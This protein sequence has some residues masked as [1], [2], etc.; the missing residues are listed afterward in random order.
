MAMP[1]NKDG[2]SKL[3]ELQN[4][5]PISDKIFLDTKEA[6]ALSGIGYGKIYEIVHRPDV[7]FVVNQGNRI[8]I[9]REKFIKWLYEATEF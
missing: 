4:S 1:K 7:N 2:V 6:S 9:H 5:V 8:L 3:V